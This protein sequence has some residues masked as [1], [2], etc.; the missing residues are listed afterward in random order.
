MGLLADYIGELRTGLEGMEG[1][2]GAALEAG[3]GGD[4]SRLAMVVEAWVNSR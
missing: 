3:P 1:R 4:D 2:A